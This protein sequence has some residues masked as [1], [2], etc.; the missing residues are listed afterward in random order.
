MC[1]LADAGARSEPKRNCELAGLPPCGWCELAT[2]HER[3]TCIRKPLRD[4]GRREPKA[5]VRKFLTQELE[6]VGGEI[7]DEKP[8]AMCE[9]PCGL[10]DGAAWFTQK[11]QDLVH[12][13]HVGHSVRKRQVVYVAVT[14][15]GVVQPCSAELGARI[16]QHGL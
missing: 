14:D 7:H 3:Q 8:T 4:L 6:L 1:P 5:F 9:H 12:D 16:T 10:L 13:D 15:L 11:V 2:V